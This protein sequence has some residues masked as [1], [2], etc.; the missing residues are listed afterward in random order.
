VGL[1]NSTTLYVAGAGKLDVVDTATLAVSRSG[2]AIG[3]GFHHRM[4]LSG[5]RLFIGART[6]ST[7]CL[8]VLDTSALTATVSPPTGDV[9]G[10]QA[11]S[12][13]NRVYLV[14]GGELVIYDTTTG[15]P[16]AL[17]PDIVGSLVDVV[18]VD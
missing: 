18:L 3:D 1:L 4:V 2:I 8:S 16:I 11:I 15:Q 7:G 6:C 10:M 9:T 14:E 5:N 17:Q 13:R 12:D